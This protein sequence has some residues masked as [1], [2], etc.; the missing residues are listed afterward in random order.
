MGAKTEA[1][2]AQLEG[3]ARDAVATLQKLGDA[4]WK[5]VT[6]GQ[7]GTLPFQLIT[8]SHAALYFRGWTA[9]RSRYVRSPGPGTRCANGSSGLA[10]PFTSGAA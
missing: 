1:L 6:A 7:F 2:A 5:K 9:M 8:Q 10:T 3:K 4:D